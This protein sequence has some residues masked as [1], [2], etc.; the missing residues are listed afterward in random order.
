MSQV[1]LKNFYYAT[2]SADTASD[3][4]TA[5]STTYGTPKK[6][7]NAVSIEVSPA[8][9]KTSLY[10]D[11]MAVATDIS[12]GEVTV[13]IETTDIPLEDQAILLGHT[14]DS[15][16][17]TVTSKSSDV[18]PYVGLAFESQKGEGGIRCVKLFKG[19]FAPSDESYNTK[20]ENI[21]Y[22]VPQ[23]EGT[24]VARQSDGAW[25]MIKDFASGAS[26]DEW[27]TSF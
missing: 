25:K 18:A 27:Y 11:D 6:I 2:I 4:S 21:E 15:V 20:G 7:G 22:Q 5:G 17:G 1:G 10:G 9:N 16:S 12:F 23:I 13:T 19:K 26:T 3:G 14:Y 8:V 24:F